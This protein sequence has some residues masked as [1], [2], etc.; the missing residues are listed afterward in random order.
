MLAVIST[1]SLSPEYLP[2]MVKRVSFIKGPSY[3]TI[4]LCVL[5]GPQ[6]CR[7]LKKIILI[8]NC[9]A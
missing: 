4:Y 8:L 7:Y 3:G 9:F 5:L 2:I 1:D 6:H